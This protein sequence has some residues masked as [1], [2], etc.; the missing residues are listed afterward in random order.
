MACA[1]GGPRDGEGRRRGLSLVARAGAAPHDHRS[2]RREEAMS[3][4]TLTRQSRLVTDDLYL[5]A[6]DDRPGRPLLAPR[7]LSIGLTGALLAELT[8]GSISVWRDALVICRNNQ[9]RCPGMGA[10]SV[11][12]AS[13]V[14]VLVLAGCSSA[15]AAAHPAAS[16]TLP[17]VP[18]ISVPS[19][20]PQVLARQAYLGMWRVYVAASRTADYQSAALA[21]YAAGGALSELTR[22]LYQAWQAG[23]VTRGNPSFD[24]HVTVT[25]SGATEQADVTDCGNVSSWGDY[26]R[27]GK[28]APGGKRGAQRI[29]ARL[30]P[31]DG[32]WKVTYLVV[33]PVGKPEC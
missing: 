7:A 1:P 3:H 31:F 11:R 25:S 22:G 24:P 8:L 29:Y 28:S 32:A 18:A 20:S 13:V 16:R 9:G 4:L 12:L 27:S 19:G 33:D 6:H 5:L 14:L 10:V 17:P 21:R 26:Y 15:P 23:I 2:S 30:Q